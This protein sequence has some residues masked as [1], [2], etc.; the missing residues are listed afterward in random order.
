[1]QEGTTN[2]NLRNVDRAAWREL[3]AE[4]MRDGISVAE[5]VRRAII[6]WLSCKRAVATEK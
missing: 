3:R 1:M 5:A 2:L 4:A 6:A